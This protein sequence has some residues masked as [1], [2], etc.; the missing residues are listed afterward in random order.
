MKVQ[1]R[2]LYQLGLVDELIAEP[3]GGA[4]RDHAAAAQALKAAICHHLGELRKLSQ[5]ELVRQRHAKFRAI[6][7][8]SEE[9]VP[10]R[11]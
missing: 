2:D 11:G 1:A 7:K 3:L 4:H 8:F 6:G 9:A 5:D 10:V